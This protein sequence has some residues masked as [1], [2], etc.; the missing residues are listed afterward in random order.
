M[1][2]GCDSYGIIES[3]PDVN[4]DAI[5]FSKPQNYRVITTSKDG[6][7]SKNWITITVDPNVSQCIV[8][9]NNTVVI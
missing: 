4:S 2:S 9:Y 3:L 8:T 5:S 6:S 7:F 1:V